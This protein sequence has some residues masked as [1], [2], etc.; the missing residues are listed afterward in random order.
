[1]TEEAQKSAIEDDTWEQVYTKCR[2]A[3][4]GVSLREFVSNPW[5]VLAQHGQSAAPESI[6]NGYE[7]LLPRQAE[8]ARRLVAEELVEEDIHQKVVPFGKKH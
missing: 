6:A 8:V 5:K 4:H 1:M 3:Q 7:P 2:L